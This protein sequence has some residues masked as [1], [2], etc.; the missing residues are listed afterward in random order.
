MLIDTED[1]RGIDIRLTGHRL[2]EQHPWCSRI[3]ETLAICAG[4]IGTRTLQH[5]I[6]AQSRPIDAFRRSA[7]Q[8]FHAVAID[9]QTIAFDFNFTREA[10]VGGVEACQV[11]DAGHI[12]QIVD[13]DDFETRLR[14]SLE[15]RSQDATANTAVAVEC[16]FVGTRLR[17]G[18]LD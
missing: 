8:Y 17:H 18:V 12:G 13:R 9:M 6:D 15:Q 10:P 5:Q 16:N 7:A 4:V 11:F 3:E 2:R 1:N 14:P